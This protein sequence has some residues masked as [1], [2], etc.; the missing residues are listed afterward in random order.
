MTEGRNQKGQFKPG[1]SGNNKGRPKDVKNKRMSNY[2]VLEYL[3]KR[4]ESYLRKIEEIAELAAKHSIHIEEEN[5]EVK[6]QPNPAFDLKLALNCYKELLGLDMQV[7]ALEYKKA[8]N[9]GKEDPK[10]K[11]KGE[12]T[13]PVINLFQQ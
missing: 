11:D 6:E 8:Q 10:D 9:K 4:K 12:H 1:T 5:G 2:Q 3:G 13:T 7:T